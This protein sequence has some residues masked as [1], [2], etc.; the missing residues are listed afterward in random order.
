MSTSKATTVAGLL[1][2]AG[3]ASAPDKSASNEYTI[4][5]VK[6]DDSFEEFIVDRK[7]GDTETMLFCIES[8]DETAVIC[9][10]KEGNKAHRYVMPMPGADDGDDESE[11]DGEPDKADKGRT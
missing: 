7:P 10:A 8:H 5:V 9:A 2:L 1:L 4:P 6:A 3:C 11:S